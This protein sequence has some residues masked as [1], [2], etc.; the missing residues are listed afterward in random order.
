MTGRPD[1][2]YMVPGRTKMLNGDTFATHLSL[3]DD[4]VSFDL[5]LEKVNTIK[6]FMTF[7]C[8]ERNSFK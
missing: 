3:F 4:D 1:T 2:E 5:N 6:V 7:F 8:L